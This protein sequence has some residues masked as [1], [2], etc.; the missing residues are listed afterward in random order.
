MITLI[1]LKTW[2]LEVYFQPLADLASYANFDNGLVVLDSLRKYLLSTHKKRLWKH[3]SKI[4]IFNFF[5]KFL[6]KLN[7]SR[8]EI[9]NLPTRVCYI[10]MYIFREIRFVV[11]E[12]VLNICILDSLLNVRHVSWFFR[13][14]FPRKPLFVVL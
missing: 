5:S 8:P 14:F 12:L 13:N 1:E 6:A 4:W 9:R 11:S 10:P 7:V 3:F 2:N